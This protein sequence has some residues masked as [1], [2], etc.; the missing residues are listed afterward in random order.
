M[1]YKCTKCGKKIHPEAKV[2][3]GNKWFHRTAAG[4]C[5]QLIGHL[6]FEAEDKLGRWKDKVKT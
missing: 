3:I 4:V 1:T 5:G 2:K 6:E